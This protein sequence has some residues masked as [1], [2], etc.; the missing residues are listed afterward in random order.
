MEYATS[1]G[2]RMMKK[3]LK[4]FEAFNKKWKKKNDFLQNMCFFVGRNNIS[5]SLRRQMNS[6]AN[7]QICIHFAFQQSSSRP[8]TNSNENKQIFVSSLIQLLKF[9]FFFS[10]SLHV[11]GNYH[12]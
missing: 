11:M 12:A 7:F 2:I 8:C 10:Y 1:Q 3:K 9:M 4:K 6:N 5:T